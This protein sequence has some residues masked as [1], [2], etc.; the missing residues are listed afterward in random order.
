M[1]DTRND[2]YRRPWAIGCRCPT[3]AACD[4]AGR[5][6]FRYTRLE[7]G[8][9]MEWP[10][11]GE[12][13][14][15]TARY[16]TE[17]FTGRIPMPDRVAF[18]NDCVESDTDGLRTWLE[19]EGRTFKP[20]IECIICSR[21]FM[22]MWSNYRPHS[23]WNN[24]WGGTNPT[25]GAQACN[26]AWRNLRRRKEKPLIE[27]RHCGDHFQ[28]TRSDSQYCSDACRQKSY[29]RRKANVLVYR[30]HAMNHPQAPN[31]TPKG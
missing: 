14:L 31:T 2:P 16:Y 17:D 28:A 15:I 24:G 7:C 3:M 19:K 26:H 23:Q 4:A 22:D 11:E 1:T 21:P 6:H 27:C 20:N 12:P 29:R 10:P 8:G 9:C 18:C 13:V 25:C 30:E 5:C